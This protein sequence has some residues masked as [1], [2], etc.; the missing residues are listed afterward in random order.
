M[1][2]SPFPLYLVVLMVSERYY[3][4][5]VAVICPIQPSSDVDSFLESVGWLEVADEEINISS[6]DQRKF[7]YLSRP[8]RIL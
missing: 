6:V 3:P 7:Y 2:F 1:S 4:G 8:C 5:D